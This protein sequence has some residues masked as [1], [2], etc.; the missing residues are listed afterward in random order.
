VPRKKKDPPV[1]EEVGFRSDRAS[2]RIALIMDMVC[3][4]CLKSLNKEAECP[5]CLY[6]AWEELLDERHVDPK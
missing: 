5:C 6:I 4:E 3:P 2:F 1:T